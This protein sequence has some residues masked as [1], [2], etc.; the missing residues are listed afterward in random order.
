MTDDRIKHSFD[1]L[2]RVYGER[3][4]AMLRELHICVVGVGGV[5]SWAA[6][7]LARTA[8]GR[9]TL[10]DA[11]DVS[12]GNINRQI[13]AMTTT[14]ENSKVDVMQRRIQDINPGCNCI[15]I[16]DML[17]ETT[18]Q[19][20]ISN[21]FDYVIDAI[22]SIRFKSALINYCRRAKIRI[23]TTGGAGGR[24]DPTQVAVADL[25][26]TWN[27]ALAAKVRRRLRAQ[28]GFSRNPQR[29]FGVECVFSSEQPVFP[30]AEGD[31]THEKPGVPGAT[32]DCDSGYGSSAS[33][34]G[35]FGLMA[36]SRAINKSLARKLREADQA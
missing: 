34:T 24:I 11:D 25:S 2:D 30:S 33:V 19:R 12:A 1:A 6:E 3:R 7:A 26:L 29:R 28:Y 36:A 20:Y 22:D 9:I 15:A 10:I 14:L 18:M 35:T 31:I 16:D 5:G 27:D 32:L 23:V 4:A 8:V 13:H 17:V 21:E